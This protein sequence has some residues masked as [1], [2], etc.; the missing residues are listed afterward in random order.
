MIYDFDRITDRKGTMCIKYD[1]RAEHR[2]NEDV[3]P[4]WVADMDFPTAE[5][6]IRRLQEAAAHGIFGYTEAK[7]EYYEAVKDWYRERFGWDI[8]K[9]WI[10]KTPG[11]VFALCAA[12]RALTKEGEAVLIQ[13]PVYYPFSNA[14]VSNGRKLVNSPLVLKDNRYEIDFEDFEN[15]IVLEQVKLFILCSPHNPVGRV[16]SERELRKIG[17]ICLKHGVLIVSDEI[18][19]DFVWE[20]YEH[21]MLAELDPAF[22]DITV[23]ATAPSKTFNLAGLQIS[24]IVISNP[25]LRDRF[26]EELNRTGYGI[27]GCMGIFAC[28][29]AY[30]EGGEWLAQCKAYIAGN[31]AFMK[32]YLEEHL[33]MLHMT[34]TEGTYLVWVDFRDLGLSAEKLETF[35]AEKTGLWLD[36][37]AMFGE[38][39]A[40]F[41]RFNVACP[42][43]VL[44]QA[45]EKLEQAVKELVLYGPEKE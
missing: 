13:R 28:E 38:E 4:M 2:M 14:I 40:G 30:R 15:R 12:V 29:A 7:D 16:W 3:I 18:H 41:Q 45:L 43:S 27:S 17:E 11:V 32:S 35:V 5:P 31:I 19:S 6:V 42:R 9:E 36:G 23:T 21:H 20:G 10:V 26:Q 44:K 22:A 1:F 39:G 25:A 24:N 37:G 8:E 33:P 34:E